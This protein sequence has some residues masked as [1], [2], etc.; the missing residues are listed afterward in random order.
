MTAA[1]RLKGVGWFASCVVVVLGFYLVSLQVASERGKLEAVNRRIDDAERDVRALETEFQTRANLTQ[2]EKW[3]GDSLASMS[4]GYEISV[5]ALQM[6]SAFATIANDGVRIQPHIVKEIRQSNDQTN[7]TAEPAKSQIISARSAGNL[8]R[9][10]RQVVLTGTGKRAQLAGYTSAGKTGTAWKY[11]A[12][13]KRVNESKYVSS[14]IGFAPAE[15]PGVVIAVVMDE[16]QGGARDGGQ[17]SAPVFRDIAEDIL[18]ELGIK[19]DKGGESLDAL[20]AEDIPETVPDAKTA[21]TETK[22]EKEKTLKA[23]AEKPGEGKNAAK[24]DRTKKQSGPNKAVG[25]TKP[26]VND[27]DRIKAAG[28]DRKT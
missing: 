28:K 9:M 23:V 5:T 15:N 1:H 7:P 16:P 2:L 19:P 4:I 14:F 26:A 3:N 22:P 12:K 6:S 10:L 21:G 20:T 18:P 27:K 25:G 11:D 24:E 17:V 13:L 8:R